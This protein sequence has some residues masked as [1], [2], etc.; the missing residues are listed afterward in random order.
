M[1][2]SALIEQRKNRFSELEHAIGDPDL[3]AD[4]K[5]AT[6]T[7]R[8]HR[9]L[10]E[11]L[12]IAE[13]LATT[14]RQL[15]EN[16]E[17][18]KSDEPEFA[19][20][21]HA[22]IPFLEKEIPRLTSDLQYALLPADPNEDRDALIEIRAGAGGDE[23]SLF[24]AELMRMYQRYAERRGW[25]SEHLE[26][27]P[28]EVG[29]FKEVILRISGDEV[30][31]Y[32]KYESGVHRVQRVPATEAQGRVHTS[33]VTVAVLPEAEEVDVVIDPNDLQID[34]Y[35][36]SGPGGQSVNTTD[37]AVRLT[38]KPTGI[39][40]TCQDEKSQL[41]NKEK[42]MRILRS[43]LLQAAEEAPRGHG[44]AEHRAHGRGRRQGA[45]ARGQH[46]AGEEGRQAHR[47][48]E[49]GIRHLF[50]TCT[51]FL[52]LYISLS[53]SFSVPFPVPSLPPQ[54]V[55]RVGNRVRSPSFINI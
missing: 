29:G 23:A 9:R 39:V 36:S 13:Q 12:A 6:E 44:V 43:R 51:F 22:E 8:E 20:M 11:T 14:K 3:F 33:T 26:S 37:S 47:A 46:R 35:R 48:A 41:Q 4:P 54:L 1:D 5:R 27:S 19:E 45:G 40:V 52:S 28:S 15:E 10:K 17:M 32:L 42:A 31:R 55:P 16:L 34:V 7:L 53:L 18:A 24:A 38:H 21:A 30:F 25:K 50:S 49:I 2:Y